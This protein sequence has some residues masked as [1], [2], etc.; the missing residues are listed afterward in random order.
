MYY[1]IIKKLILFIFDT[2]E[3]LLHINRHGED[4]HAL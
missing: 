4:T 3:P 2:L 1:V